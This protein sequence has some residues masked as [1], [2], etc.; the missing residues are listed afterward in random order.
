MGSAVQVVG[1]G[2]RWQRLSWLRK[3]HWLHISE[4]A[5]YTAYENLKATGNAH[6]VLRATYIMCKW[7]HLRKVALLSPA[8]KRRHPQGLEIL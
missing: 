5:P 6:F 4:T 3:N 7:S 2:V 1:V 8:A